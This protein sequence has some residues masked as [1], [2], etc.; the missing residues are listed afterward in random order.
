VVAVEDCMVIFPS[1]AV[2][3]VVA[4]LTRVVELATGP[5]GSSPP[6]VLDAV[7]DE[8]I[9]LDKRPDSIFDVLAGQVAD[10]VDAVTSIIPHLPRDERERLSE[11]IA[12]RLLGLLDLMGA[13]P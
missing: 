4:F 9:A 10:A 11:E 6:A 13:K 7:H 1:S 8:L 12:P 3:E 5:V 2:S